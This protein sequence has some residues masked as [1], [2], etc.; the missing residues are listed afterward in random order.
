LQLG[1]GHLWN[2]LALTAMAGLAALPA[3]TISAHAWLR[4]AVPIL[5]AT[6]GMAA[7]TAGNHPAAKKRIDHDATP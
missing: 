5:L 3:E 1:D 4:T 2:A 7:K 6:I